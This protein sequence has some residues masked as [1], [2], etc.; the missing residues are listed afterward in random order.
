MSVRPLPEKVGVGFQSEQKL[1]NTYREVNAGHCWYYFVTPDSWAWPEHPV[2]EKNRIKI[3]GFSPN[4]NKKLH[5]GHLRQLAIANCLKS[6]LPHA[7]FV[8]LLGTTGILKQSVDDLNEWF[9]FLDF[10][11]KLYYDALMPQDLEI[12]PRK[13]GEGDKEGA[14]VWDGPHGPV[15]VMR[16]ADEFGFRRTTYAFHDLA[17]A[18]TVKPDY[19]LT[20]V[21]QVKHFH[22]LGLESKHLPMGLVMDADRKKL[23]SRNGDVFMAE[24]AFRLVQ[25]AMQPVPD[26]K[27][28]IWNVIAWNMLANS[29]TTYVQFEPER[30]VKPESP[31]MYI[32]Y[33]WARLKSALG[34]VDSEGS[35]EMNQ[36]DVDLVGYSQYS[37]FHVIKT[38]ATMDAVGLANYLYNLCRRVTKA[39]HS[40]KIRD[41]RPGF[42]FAIG[43]CFNVISYCMKMLGMFPIHM[44]D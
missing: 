41:G 22:D 13:N 31:G 2:V 17:F 27:R 24:D 36:S 39:Y 12:V 26:P 5:V 38:Q 4:L 10:K 25:E 33:T 18:A 32:S 9:N 20:G 14:L 43:K 15:V 19:Y 8:S 3:D 37:Y 35:T 7:D 23:K 11:P 30:W 44:R 29:R 1:T 16:K 34:S 6:V 42:R 40:E 28:I 21:E